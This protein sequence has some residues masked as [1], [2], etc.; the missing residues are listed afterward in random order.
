[1]LVTTHASLGM[2]IV[3]AVPNPLISL[4]LAFASHFVLD[5]ILHWPN[6]KKKK[7]LGNKIYKLAASDAVVAAIFVGV[8]VGITE[9]ANLLWGAVA[10]SIMDVDAVFYDKKFIHIFK[11]P[12]PKFISRFHGKIQNETGSLWG[13]V[14]QII[15]IL[16]SVLTIF[17]G[18]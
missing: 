2:A 6:D 15:L 13:V 7:L 4:P 1:M 8:M 10:A 12:L 17:L 18:V 9:N 16:A 14:M 3:S 11:T 5:A